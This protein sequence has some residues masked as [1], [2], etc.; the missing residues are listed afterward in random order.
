MSIK[1]AGIMNAHAWV[2]SLGLACGISAGCN[3][4]EV[5][6]DDKREPAPK[7]Y[8]KGPHGGRLLS[9]AKLQAEVTIYE[10]G[11]PPQFRVY[12]YADKKPLS[13]AGVKLDIT[14]SRLGGRV[15][16]IAFKPEGDYLVG[17]KVVE[18]PH[19]FDVAVTAQRAGTTHTWKY[20]QREGRV[21][22]S[23]E[24][25]RSSDI[26]IETVGPA[27]MRTA[28]EM[29]GEISLNAD[30]VAH[31]VPR[32]SGILR[33]IRKN[34]G[35]LVKKG[36]IIAVLDS[37]ELAET[38]RV[39]L[40]S[41]Y[42]LVF[43]QKSFARE[44]GLWKKNI[45]SEASYLEQERMYQEARLKHQSARQQL[46]ALGIGKSALQ[47]LDKPDSDLTRYELRSPFEG[48]LIEK[49]VATGQA[50]KEY[51][52]LFTVADLSSVWVNVTVYAKDLNAV[53]VGQEVTVRSDALD[54]TATAKIVYVGSLVGAETRSAQ[55]RVVL[56]NDQGQWRAGMFVNVSVVQ[57]EQT[58]PV[59]VKRA[60]LQ[61]FRDWDVVF[62]RAGNEFEARPLEL[63]RQEGE[64]VEVLSGLTPGE[65]YAST[66]SFVL[67]ADVG[68]A[69]AS[70]D[71]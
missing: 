38:K 48:V 53:K 70:H 16:R 50:V 47:A 7:E 31:V 54:T 11:I 18:E 51:D 59:A 61:K 3:S 39:Y 67:K 65:R 9:D 68:K 21:E 33:E 64:W 19:S 12:L 4:D 43:A 36:E 35:D 62:V 32:M 52:D 63:G 57:N 17:D 71:H 26:Q 24:A 45:A 27:K 15:D 56:L 66:N 60:G 28:L 55:A 37:R 30:K 69:G 25:V 41:T 5:G 10:P 8:D 6:F 58:V 49:T 2:L 1:K 29:P 22:L 13:P 46:E 20:S 44:E 23:E 42:E 40:E 14:L 34:Q